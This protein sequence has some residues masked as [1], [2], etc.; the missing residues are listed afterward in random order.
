M[1]PIRH[2]FSPACLTLLVFFSFCGAAQ[3]QEAVWYNGKWA[4]EQHGTDIPPDS[5]IIFGRL[6]NGVRYAVIP[7]AHPKGR[8]SIYLNVQAGS[9]MENPDESGYAHFVEHMA[10]NGSRNFAPGTLIHFF[11]Q[12]GMSF[13]GD[14]NAHTSRLET[15]YKLHLAD[16]KEASLVMGLTVLR[17]FADGIT[18]DPLEVEK[19]K[20]VILAEKN[21]RDSETM[22]NRRM[23]TAVLYAGTAFVNQTIGTEESIKTASP[24]KLRHFYRKWYHPERMV[25]VAVGDVT[26]EQII[27]LV[28]RSFQSVSNPGP[29]PF[30]DS[31]GRITPGGLVAEAEKRDISGEDI[32]VIMRF[33]RHHAHDSR[34]WRRNLLL[35]RV[36]AQ[37]MRQRL[38]ARDQRDS[39]WNSARFMARREGLQ[40]SVS[41][42]A[43]TSSG[44]WHKALAALARE[45]ARAASAGFSSQEVSYALTMIEN[46]LKRSDKQRMGKNSADVADEFVSTVNADTVCTSRAFDLEMFGKQRPLVTP[47]VVNSAAAEMLRADDI[48]VA[49]GSTNPPERDEIARVWREGIA[50]AGTE[51]MP[52]LADEKKFPYLPLPP[53]A[54]YPEPAVARHIVPT[55]SEKEII[56]YEADIT[57]HLRVH[58]MPLTFEPNRAWVHLFFGRGYLPQN[59]T[60]ALLA[61]TASAVLAGSGMGALGHEAT[62]R[63]ASSLGGRVKEMHGPYHAGISIS[64]DADR[65]EGLMQAVWTQFSDPHIDEKA[66]QKTIRTLAASERTRRETVE[67]LSRVEGRAFFYGNATHFLS[68]ETD[69]AR[70][71]S[72]DALRDFLRKSRRAGPMHLVIGGDIDQAKTLELAQRYFAAF[73]PQLSPAHTPAPLNFPAGKEVSSEVPDTV[74]QS[75]VRRAW[76]LDWSPE[77]GRK[78]LLARQMAASVLRDD[79][80]RDLRE[81]LGVS[82]SPSVIYRPLPRENN[83]ALL[84]AD[85]SAARAHRQIV[86]DY[87]KNLAP[88]QVEAEELDRLRKPMITHLRANRTNARYWQ[89]MLDAQVMTGLP[90]LD[91]NFSD[92]TM[93]GTLTPA[94]VTAALKE[95]LEA[96]AATWS[97]TAAGSREKNEK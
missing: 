31:W 27:P 17:D 82:Y 38:L 92:E 36:V 22:R 71:C 41:M 80:R 37:C 11:Q 59:D 77:D 1:H 75:F 26:P 25:V 33:D 95:L 16:T 72:L 86:T 24:E 44:G 14:T 9:L 42:V 97:V 3:P 61:R 7:N 73:T 23:R 43:S 6:D 58:I 35:D 70:Q 91:W 68:L 57:P 40:P 20:G 74:D 64:G 81:R 30:P 89:R 39:L 88:R 60:D 94:D 79:L 5:A 8:V 10:F 29:L 90:Y 46:D 21:A 51:T 84:E 69:A 56:V 47:S 18:F 13:G 52:T 62:Q 48:F 76:R 45:T 4:H 63:L 15:V 78:T 49:V 34:E 65:L 2:I 55:G 50:A 54:T 19:E 87:L 96:P 66:L 67:A 93:L 85:V 32:A 12:H 28:S 53:Q 83:F